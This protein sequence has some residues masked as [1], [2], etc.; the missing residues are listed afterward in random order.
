M[1]DES[2]E[3]NT[4]E[5]AI[6]MTF[7][8]KLKTT[9]IKF[10]IPKFSTELQKII[11]DVP[12]T[13][14][15]LKEISWTVPATKMERRCISK[16]PVTTCKRRKPSLKYPNPLP[17]CEVTMECIYMDVPVVYQ[18]RMDIKV[19]MPVFSMR[20]QEFS[21]DKPVITF[22]TIEIKLDLP[23]FHLRDLS[24]DLQHQED[25]YEEIGNDMETQVNL[26]KNEMDEDLITEIGG[27]VDV[28]FDEIRK[29][30]IDE[31]GNVSKQFDDAIGKMKSAIKILKGNNATSETPRLESE[32]AK[33]VEDYKIVLNEIDLSIEQLNQ[34]QLEVINSIKLQ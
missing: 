21:F 9:S 2:P 1:T 22:E 16:R 13:K 27:T 31:R 23:Q 24:A 5:V 32:L 20:K 34:E 4:A 15:E 17:K 8:V 26:A 25:E 12:T 18:K 19:D 29:Q 30:L 14:M 7:D 3:P 28:I 33:L 6:D 11:F 10:D